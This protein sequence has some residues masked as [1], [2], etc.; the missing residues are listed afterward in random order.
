MTLNV[1]R[2]TNVAP[3]D[4][5]LDILNCE[6]VCAGRVPHTPQPGNTFPVAYDPPLPELWTAL[7]ISNLT[8]LFLNRLRDLRAGGALADENLSAEMLEKEALARHYVSLLCMDTLS[9]WR[10]LPRPASL[11]QI[12]HAR[13][14]LSTP[15]VKRRFFA[16]NVDDSTRSGGDRDRTASEFSSDPPDV[17][18]K[19]LRLGEG[20]AEVRLAAD[21]ADMEATATLPAASGEGGVTLS[22]GSDDDPTLE[23]G[24]AESG[25][26]TWLT[27]PDNRDRED[28][29]IPQHQFTC[30]SCIA[31]STLCKDMETKLIP[32]AQNAMRNR[33]QERANDVGTGKA[34][35]EVFFLEEGL[36]HYSSVRAEL[37]ALAD[38]VDRLKFGWLDSAIH[39]CL[40]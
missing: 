32:E 27:C 12:E 5:A 19:V 38:E 37:S 34:L 35:L 31:E 23:S 21:L 6:R 33:F 40:F 39:T 16:A 4:L 15:L 18:R 22:A 13:V 2:S 26:S 8:I 11:P 3:T 17:E 30:E 14:S 7:D 36:R 29:G 25:G 28:E 1:R 24:S 20:I 9:A 10:D